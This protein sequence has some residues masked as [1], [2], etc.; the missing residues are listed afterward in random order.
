MATLKSKGRLAIN[1]PK[2]F[3]IL[4]TAF[5]GDVVLATPLIE[6]LRAAYP[7]AAIDFLARKGNESL[8]LHHP[9]LRHVWCFDKKHK[10]KSMWALIRKL[11]RE[12]YDLLLNLHRFASSGLIAI[13]AGAQQTHGF[14]KNPFSFAYTRRFAHSIDYLLPNAPHEVARNLSLLEGWADTAFTPPRLYPPA[15]AA[16]GAPSAPYICIA[17]TSVWFTKQWPA[18]KW[19]AL[20]RQIPD[21]L[22]VVLLGAPGDFETCEKIRYA[23]QHPQVLNMAGKLS[24]LES[25][26]WMR[27]ARMN[28][29][30]DSAPIHLA[31][32]VDAPITAVFC[33]TVPGFG[34]GPLSSKAY[35]VETPH[36]LS[37]RPCG[38]HG[39]RACPQGHFRCAMDIQPEQ[40][41]A[42]SR[43]H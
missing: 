32:A 27:G 20:I 1:M 11:R 8:L 23:S 3:L 5:L 6:K 9:Y 16:N 43:L 25:A 15:D 36:P 41:L 14:S 29:A 22:Q 42:I 38:L 26:A 10:I 21:S 35:M 7:D 24:L 30:N 33:S 4:Q 19:I 17:P 34:F 13:C 31:S 28:Y 37:C 12:R 18:E 2:K 39:F 40:V